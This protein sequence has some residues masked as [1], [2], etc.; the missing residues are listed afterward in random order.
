MVLGI[1]EGLVECATV[2]VKSVVILKIK[3]PFETLL[4]ELRERQIRYK[5]LWVVL[6]S[7]RDYGQTESPK[8]MLTMAIRRD[9][10]TFKMWGHS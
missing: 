3:M 6:I 4:P 9:Y 7:L 1:K 8:L 2:C 10:C 5:L